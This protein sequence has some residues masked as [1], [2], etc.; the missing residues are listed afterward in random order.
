MW[1]SIP[2]GPEECDLWEQMF[3]VP[4]PSLCQSKHQVLVAEGTPMF[5]YRF[6]LGYL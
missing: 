4:G 3:R 6:N 1:E 5:F 2:L